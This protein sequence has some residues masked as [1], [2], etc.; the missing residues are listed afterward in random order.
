[1]EQFKC[2]YPNDLDLKKLDYFYKLHDIAVD[3]IGMDKDRTQHILPCGGSVVSET[4]AYVDDVAEF[5]VYCRCGE[6]KTLNTEAAIADDEL[7]GW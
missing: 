6:C 5:H 1:M 4:Y 3:H 7:K 2:Y